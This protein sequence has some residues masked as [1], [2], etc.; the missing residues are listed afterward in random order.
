MIIKMISWFISIV[1]CLF[2]AIGGLFGGIFSPPGG[3]GGTT[4]GRPPVIAPYIDP[5]FEEPSPSDLTPVRDLVPP[6]NLNEESAADQLAYFNTAVNNVRTARPRI[7]RT[8]LLNIDRI[9]VDGGMAAVANPIVNMIKNI[10]MPGIPEI[11]TFSAGSLNDG[12]FLCD[13]RTVASALRLEDITTINSVRSGSGWKIEVGIKSERDPDKRYSAN[14]RIYEIV[15]KHEVLWEI[16]S[17][18]DMIR[19]DLEKSHLDYSNGFAWI[20]VNSSG[21]VTSAGS[22]FKVN[23]VANDVFIGPV[24]GLTVTATQTTKRDYTINW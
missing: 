23:C 17:I 6:A 4:P 18:S 24:R 19:A 5:G 10:L 8:E 9:S 2:S 15:C 21:Q 11:Q 7:T 14:G 1:M 20:V 12:F 22:G 3:G 16:V 13:F